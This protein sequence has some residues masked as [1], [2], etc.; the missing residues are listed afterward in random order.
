M[1]DADI[2]RSFKKAFGEN[3]KAIRETKLKSL[4]QVDSNTKY[5]KSNF[6]KYEKGIGNPTLE[7]IFSIANALDVEPKLLL[8]FNFDFKLD[9]KNT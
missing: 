5:N 6:H 3:L 1:K 8:D 4:G 7:T 9:D 2:L